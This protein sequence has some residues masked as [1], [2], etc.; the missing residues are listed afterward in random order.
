MGLLPGKTRSAHGFSRLED[1]KINSWPYYCTSRQAFLPR[2]RRIARAEHSPTHI[3]SH[4]A[5]AARSSGLQTHPCDER[6]LSFRKRE[7]CRIPYLSRARTHP[8]EQIRSLDF[9][10]AFEHSEVRGDV[11]CHYRLEFC[12]RHDAVTAVSCSRRNIQNLLSGELAR[13][14]CVADKL[15]SEDESGDCT[16]N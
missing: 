6:A 7:S 3:R 13:G 9:C 14:R 2:N 8:P 15:L 16:F 1:T 12:I 11:G 4:L 5:P 10:S